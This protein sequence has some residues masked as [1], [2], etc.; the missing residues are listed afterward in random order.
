M[1]RNIHP[2]YVEGSSVYANSY[3]F[4]DEGGSNWYDYCYSD[5]FACGFYIAEGKKS[6]YDNCYCYWYSANG[7]KQVGM[8]S[9][10]KFNSYV[11]HFTVN[12]RKESAEADKE[13]SIL[14]VGASGGQGVIEYLYAKEERVKSKPH[15]DY[16]IG[17][18]ID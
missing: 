2:L 17:K 5:Q 10:G 6:V 8:R 16:L 7:G 18:V 9:G 1:L 14:E 15:L 12:F 11:S 13:T 3:G 4:Y